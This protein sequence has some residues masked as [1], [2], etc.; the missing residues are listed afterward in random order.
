MAKE[1]PLLSLRQSL[2][3]SVDVR[4]KAI[5]CGLPGVSDRLGLPREAAKLDA[6]KAIARGG[7]PREF[8]HDAL[9][10]QVRA[11]RRRQSIPSQRPELSRLYQYLRTRSQ[12]IPR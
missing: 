9:A 10:P 6:P 12:T 5:E 11:R 2:P 3:N 1:P 8:F 4:A 7:R